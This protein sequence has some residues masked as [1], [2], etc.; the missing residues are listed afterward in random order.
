MNIMD[1][2]FDE[3]PGL[4]LIVFDFDKTLTK[5]HTLVSENGIPRSRFQ[6]PVSAG[7]LYQEVTDPEFI[8]EFVLAALDKGINVAVA[9]FNDRTYRVTSDD[10][11]GYPLIKAFMDSIFPDNPGIFGKK[12][13]IA[14]RPRNPYKVGKAV[15]LKVLGKRYLLKPEE[16][17]LFDDNKY[18]VFRAL[19]YGYQGYLVPITGF[20]RNYVKKLIEP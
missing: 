20:D 10:L 16:I 11:T 17:M 12:N 1:R 7:Q 18:N 5:T 4:K 6:A 13:I 15:H 9:S 19:D 8:Q 14:Y 3:H 2:F